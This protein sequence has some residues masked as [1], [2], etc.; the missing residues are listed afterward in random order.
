M[1]LESLG[2]YDLKT[3]DFGM[4]LLPSTGIGGGLI[5]LAISWAK[6]A[7]QKNIKKE[8]FNFIVGKFSELHLK[9][10]ES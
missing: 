6:T 8:N 7:E 2:F 10:A 1:S 5:G 9:R 3:Y 4:I